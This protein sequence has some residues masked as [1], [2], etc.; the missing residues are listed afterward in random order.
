MRQLG[1]VSLVVLLT[2]T[3]VRADP[4]TIVDTGRG[5]A[6]L[7]GF[8]LDSTQWLAVEF[9]VATPAVISTVQGWILPF[10][11]GFLD[12]SLYRGGGAVPG[13][14]LFRNTGFIDSGSADWRGLSA[15]TWSVVPGT[16]WV[17]FETSVHPTVFSA[18]PFPSEHPLRNGAVL[19]REQ[20]E[21]T[22]TESDAIAQIGVRIFGEATPS[23]V[24]EPASMLLVSTGLAGVFAY[25]RR[26]RKC[27][28]PDG[29]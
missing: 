11:G 2:S 12:V 26:A 23:A 5:P 3:A 18:M 1:V 20:N 6:N 25:R 7:P 22:Y 9:D 10:S 27:P 29:R 16:Y 13:P 8:L 19:D 24:P 21:T 4:V 14:L 28:Q 17:A 15:L